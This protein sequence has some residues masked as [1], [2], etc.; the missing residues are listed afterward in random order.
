MPFQTSKK[1]IA[2]EDQEDEFS[3]GGNDISDKLADPDAASKAKKKRRAQENTVC[4]L[5]LFVVMYLV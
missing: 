4:I 2:V 5:S 3:F 1:E